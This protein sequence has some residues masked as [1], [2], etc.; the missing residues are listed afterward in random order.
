[1]L[2]IAQIRQLKSIE[3]T[4]NSA[5]IGYAKACFTPGHSCWQLAERRHFVA[6]TLYLPVSVGFLAIMYCSSKYKNI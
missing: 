4:V 3:I 5:T 1:M 2:Q 6:A